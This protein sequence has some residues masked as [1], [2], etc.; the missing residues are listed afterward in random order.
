MMKTIKLKSKTTSDDFTKFCNKCEKD[1]VFVASW[2]EG[3]AKFI[4]VRFD[5]E[6]DFK[7]W[8]VSLSI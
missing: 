7:A 4:Q 2:T 8:V 3:R 6:I 1:G 5:N